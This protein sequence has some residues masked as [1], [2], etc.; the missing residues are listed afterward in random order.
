MLID[1]ATLVPS[2]LPPQEAWAR[3]L[4]VRDSA[5]A[6]LL[7]LAS[8]HVSHLHELGIA[9]CAGTLKVLELL[10]TSI[11]QLAVAHTIHLSD[12]AHTVAE[13][14][15]STAV[16]IPSACARFG[17]HLSVAST[18][19]LGVSLRGTPG[20]QPSRRVLRMVTAQAIGAYTLCA[21]YAKVRELVGP[22]LD[23]P[24]AA[25][26]IQPDFKAALISYSQSI[27]R[28]AHYKLDAQSGP[29]HKSTFTASVWTDKKHKTQGT[30][31]SK[32]AAEQAAAERYLHR[33]TPLAA[34][35]RLNIP[36]TRPHPEPSVS[37]V[38]NTR[39]QQLRN[40]ASQLGITQNG[41]GFLN[42]ALT[43][44]S[45]P[46]EHPGMPDNRMLADLGAY[47]LDSIAT[48]RLSTIILGAS[49]RDAG[50]L[51]GAVAAVLAKNNPYLERASDILG[52]KRLLLIGKAVQIPGT[53]VRVEAF[54]AV[55]GAVLLGRTCPAVVTDLLPKSLR[56]W[57]DDGLMRGAPALAE[58]IEKTK[59]SPPRTIRCEKCGRNL[60]EDF[61]ERHM[62]R[63]RVQDPEE[64]LAGVLVRHLPF[65]LLAPGT[66]D[67]RQVVEYYRKA[68]ENRGNGW[69]NGEFDPSRLE[70]IASLRPSQCYVGKE[71][72]HGYI[73]FEFA[74]TDRVVLECPIEGNAIYVLS[75]NWKL[76][77]NHT[78][79][80]LRTEYG[81]LCMR[82]VHKGTWLT[83]IQQTLR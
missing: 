54:Q 2:S 55:L 51:R 68:A 50:E 33:F 22:Y 57:L 5:M 13:A 48:Y 20:Q 18:I 7:G 34:R 45:Y 72:W 69:G 70:K 30:G 53:T 8:E 1:V 71:S 11:L 75:G 29:P 56:Q 44:S 40:P 82:I 14:S 36:H 79:A 43:H 61:A 74:N 38:T 52:I 67:M 27:G 4:G 60:S 59:S 80:E 16:A 10:G 58:K 73:V 77:I 32:D 47:A 12:V 23:Q 9:E 65:T 42:T 39:L 26:S 81:H 37:T 15:A 28:Q 31:P 25:G 64:R 78:K 21:G 17:E 66:W 41:I 62:E 3:S 19:R 24:T 83:R 49:D 46:A 76:M 63:C 6:R 35:A